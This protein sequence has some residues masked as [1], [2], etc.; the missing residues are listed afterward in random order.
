MKTLNCNGA[1]INFRC[2]GAGKNVILLHGLAANFAFWHINVLLSLARKFRVTLYDLRGHGYSSMPPSGYSTASMSEDLKCLMNQLN[3]K[4]AHLIGHSYGGAVAL[5]FATLH[6]HRVSSLTLAESRIRA[7]QPTNRLKDLPDREKIQRSLAETG[8]E[9]PDDETEIGLWLLERLALPE[10]RKKRQNLYG[11]P[12]FIPFSPWGG[13]NRTAENWLQLLSKTTARKDM[14]SLA[15]LT[16]EKIKALKIPTLLAYAEHSY[17]MPSYKGL[18]KHLPLCTSTIVPDAGHF[19]PLS[20]PDTFFGIVQDFLRKL[21]FKDRR[22]AERVSCQFPARL[23]YNDS[24]SFPAQI[25]NISRNGLLI[26]SA[27]IAAV[28]SEVCVLT[29][30]NQKGCQIA[31]AGEIVW[32]ENKKLNQSYFLGIELTSDGDDYNLWRNFERV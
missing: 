25:L 30:L 8:I 10:W 29:K 19:F 28:G 2:I 27:S 7:L 15:G 14:T 3:L 26:E 32:L 22:R 4:R 13:G 16:V 5:H 6:P 17:L 1:L 24:N 31:V 9:V 23:D 18:F 11:R 12:L 20:K 21:D